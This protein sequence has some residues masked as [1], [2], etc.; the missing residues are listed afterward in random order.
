MQ[1]VVYGL[2]AIWLVSAAGGLFLGVF[3]IARPDDAP[4]LKLRPAPFYFAS[5]AFTF[6]VAGMLMWLYFS[7]AMSESWVL[8]AGFIVFLPELAY[9]IWSSRISSGRK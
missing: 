5:S 9:F 3:S 6:A 8:V 7:G 2:F 1:Y 4:G